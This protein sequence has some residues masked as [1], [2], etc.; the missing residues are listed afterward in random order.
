MVK[1]DYNDLL[2]Q[3]DK[4]TKEDFPK[5]PSESGALLA[6]SQRSQ[7]LKK[8]LCLVRELPWQDFVK[9]A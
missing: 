1:L 4:R 2:N 6:G 7:G 5:G 8:N 3:K 9:K